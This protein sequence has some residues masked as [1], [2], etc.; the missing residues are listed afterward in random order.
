[1]RL[2]LSYAREQ[3]SLAARLAARL[4]EENHSV[5]FDRTDLEP[6]DPF[7][8]TIR[9][10]IH[11]AD[12]FIFVVSPQSVEPTSYALTELG[13]ARRRWRKAAG[14]I[15]PVIVEPAPEGSMP[16]FGV[17]YLIPK[18]DWVAEVIARVAELAEHRRHRRLLLASW[19]AGSLVVAAGVTWF[20]SDGPSPPPSTPCLLLGEFQASPTRSTS[21]PEG[22]TLHVAAGGVTN[23]FLVGRDGKCRFGIDAELV[24]DWRLDLTSAAGVPWGRANLSG[25]P[26]STTRVPLDEG[27]SITIRPQ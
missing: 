24:G 4:E 13:L 20:V 23:D 27:S 6:G 15:L 7:D 26:A 14:R 11:R 21:I 2:F 25:C 3:G 17:T 22:L 18:G 12:L 8:A 5:F 10:E 1:M 19:V 9:N 16:E